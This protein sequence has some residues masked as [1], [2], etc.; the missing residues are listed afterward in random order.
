MKHKAF[1]TSLSALLVFATVSCMTVPDPE[2]VP[3]GLSVAELNLK[4][5]ESIDESNYKAA[6]VYYNLI[7]ERY[8]AD[9]ATATSAE[10]E[11]AHIR[12]KRKDYADA[13]QRLNTIIARY[14][15][16]GGAGLPPEYLVLA[17]ND[18]ARIPEEYRTESGP[19]SAE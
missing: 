12:I 13:A 6:E 4:A 19:E 2:S 7:L 16:S 14:E 11:L 10:F 5:Q 18:L 9:P 8:G 1:F 3:D 15:T 17:R